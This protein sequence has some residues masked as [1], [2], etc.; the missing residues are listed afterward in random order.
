MKTEVSL[1]YNKKPTLVSIMNEWT[2]TLHTAESK[3]FFTKP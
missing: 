1:S 3:I 2:L